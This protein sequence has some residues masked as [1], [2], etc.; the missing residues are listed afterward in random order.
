MALG[1]NMISLSFSLPFPLWNVSS[2]S[3]NASCPSRDMKSSF[4]RVHPRMKYYL[5]SALMMGVPLSLAIYWG[6]GIFR[7]LKFLEFYN[8]PFL[9][10]CK[11]KFR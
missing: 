6:G 11:V 5:S 10:N 8:F 4:Q 3:D 9:A 7:E 1:V 2:A